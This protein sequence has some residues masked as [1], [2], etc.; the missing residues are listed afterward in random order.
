MVRPGSHLVSEYNT[1][2]GCHTSDD[3]IIKS[4]NHNH[5]PD[6]ANIGSQL[7]DS[8]YF[9]EHN[10]LIQPIVDY[11]EDTW[12]GRPG[13]RNK[14]RNPIFPHSLWNCYEATIE[15]LPKINNN[16]VEGWH[17]EFSQLLGA[18]HP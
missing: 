1:S 17:R 6:A 15:D 13:R 12:I 9:S 4:I 10:D 2:L 8:P 3:Q 18:S 5:V 11:F 16:S 7:V 14:R